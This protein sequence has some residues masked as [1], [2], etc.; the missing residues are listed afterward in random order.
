M[1][2]PAG[3]LI[4]TMRTALLLSLAAFA[5]AGPVVPYTEDWPNGKP[6]VRGQKK[7]GRPYGTWRRWHKNGKQQGHIEYVDGK[8]H[9]RVAWWHDNG[10]VQTDWEYRNG[11]P[12]NG[13]LVS[14]HANG[15]VWSKVKYVK[16]KGV[17]QTQVAWHDNGKK[18]YQGKWV[19]ELQQGKWTYWYKT[20]E[21]QRSLTFK[22]GQAN[23]WETKWDE[24]GQAISKVLWKNGKRAKK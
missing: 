19:N 20:G 3:V 7:D 17:N 1:T 2:P 21:K 22:K 8:T 23:G 4:V 15:K 16:G 11:K 5:F 13:V 12:W 6:K 24:K 10:Q 18:A 9:G 14:Y